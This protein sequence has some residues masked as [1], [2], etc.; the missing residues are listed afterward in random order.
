[1]LIFGLCFIIHEI[2][3]KNGFYR[4]VFMDLQVPV[5]IGIY[6]QEENC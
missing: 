1:M 2:S 5:D 3:G 6:M 4:S